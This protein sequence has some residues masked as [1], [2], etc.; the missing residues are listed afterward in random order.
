MQKSVLTINRSEKKN[1]IFTAKKAPL[2]I[3]FRLSAILQNRSDLSG[4][5]FLG[6]TGRFVLFTG[7]KIIFGF[8]TNKALIGFTHCNILYFILLR[9]CLCFNYLCFKR[10]W[11]L[12]KQKYIVLGYAACFCNKLQL[13][14]SVM[15]QII[16][17]IITRRRNKTTYY[18]TFIL[19]FKLKSQ[20]RFH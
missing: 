20:L 5:W 9:L 7:F 10:Q 2:Q 13:M 18:S 6:W 16:F 8:Y 12:N 19:F 17:K 3:Y 4:F 11:R 15:M 1:K 14:W